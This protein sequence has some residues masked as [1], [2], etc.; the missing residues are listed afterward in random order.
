[1]KFVVSI[2]FILS[3][4]YIFRLCA[5]MWIFGFLSGNVLLRFLIRRKNPY[6]PIDRSV[7]FAILFTRRVLGETQTKHLETRRHATK[8]RKRE[9][10]RLVNLETACSFTKFRLVISKPALIIAQ[11]GAIKAPKNICVVLWRESIGSRG[12]NPLEITSYTFFLV[13]I[14]KKLHLIFVCRVH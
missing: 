1:M 11:S 10:T 5:K 14:K 4:V 9:E 3:R 7:T 13:V 2:N 6:G 8:E 12:V